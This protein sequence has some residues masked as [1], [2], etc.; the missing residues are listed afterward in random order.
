LSG[1]G[2]ER[3]VCIDHVTLRVADLD[4]SR[5][6][7]THALA[8]LDAH[9]VELPSGEIAF[10]PAGAEDF[11]IAKG[12]PARPPLHV[13]FAAADRGQVEAF[14]VAALEAGGTDNGAPGLRPRYHPGYYA[15]FVLDP[16]GNNVE[17][18][19]HER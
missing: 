12:G 4:R 13:A 15:A 2:V 18:V 6:F 11:V 10:G 9:P 1:D 17:A 19:L 3:R 5:T 14:H 16:D 7:Y 8:P